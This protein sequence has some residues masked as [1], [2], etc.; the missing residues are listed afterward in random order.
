MMI[1]VARW[2]AGTSYSSQSKYAQADKELRAAL[3]LIKDNDQLMAGAL[4]HLGLSNYQMGKG[5]SA[6]QIGE[7][8]KFM[9]QC[10][11]IKSPFQAQAQKNLGVMRRES[12][13]AK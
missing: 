13:Q 11:A 12:G 9:Q 10:A 3:P 7:A 2:M 4:F 8:A 5:K 1:G 6:Q